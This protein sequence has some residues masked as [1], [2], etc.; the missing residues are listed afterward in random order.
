M[1]WLRAAVAISLTAATAL[2]AQAVLSTESIPLVF[3]ELLNKQ[4]LSDSAMVLIDAR[5]GE[6]IYEKNAYSQRRAIELFT[7]IYIHKMLPI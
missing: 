4:A 5:T 3:E 2:P 7:V 1:R 6:S